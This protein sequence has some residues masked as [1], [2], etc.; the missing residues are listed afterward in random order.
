MPP[1][2]PPLLWDV[3][4]EHLQEAAFLW[5]QRQRSLLA[6]DYVLA[7]IA[8]G[9]EA[10]L[11]AHVEGLVIAGRP[12]AER[13][14]LPALE[15]EEPASIAAASC[16]LLESTEPDWLPTVLDWFVQGAD[17]VR[18]GIS[19]ALSLSGRP[20]VSP[21]LVKLFPSLGELAD[22]I[23][24]L[25]VLRARQANTGPVLER[26][27]VRGEEPE[28]L[29][30][31]IRAARF[32]PGPMAEGLLRQGLEESEPRVREAALETG[33]ILGNRQAWALCR[34]LVE[35]GEAQARP[36]L[37]AVALGGEPTE[38]EALSAAVGNPAC[39]AEALWALGFSG[40]LSAAEA[41]LAALREQ[42]DPLA[43]DAFAFI[44]GLPLASV[45]AD[46]EEGAEAAEEWPEG[47]EEEE[48]QEEKGEASEEDAL[49]VLPGP[50]PLPGK[51]RV[52]AVEAWWQKARSHFE[53]GGRY[54]LGKPVKP[55]LLPALMEELPMRRRPVLGWELAIR[56]RDAC[57]LEP[58][59]WAR[60]QRKQLEAAR[61]LRAD[62]LRR[63]FARWFTT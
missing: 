42:G 21:A 35:A 48:A 24:A 7:E 40:R 16:A 53:E 5:E 20:D 62:S 43:A 59:A 28:L 30:A 25:E 50:E 3:L 2:R 12:A 38:L 18:E 47:E 57:R 1:S 55:E 14:L 27:A 45:L 8:E 46:E 26:L 61:E 54:L 60:V 4:R 63:T 56:S 52:E 37:L 22:K 23:F 33:L 15:G 19:W 49:G 31:A 11:L 29:A 10:R 17:E 51:V 44:T 13:L 9:D 39:R 34:R 41:A 36:A 6:S 32:A 58:G